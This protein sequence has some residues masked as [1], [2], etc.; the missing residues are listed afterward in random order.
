MQVLEIR[1]LEQEAGYIY[2]RR[3]YRATALLLL[4]TKNVEVPIHF[5]IE[6]N[7]AGIHTIDV[8]LEASVDYPLL[9]VVK[10]LK[11]EILNMDQ[12]G[13]LPC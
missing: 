13:L 2:Y 12:K 5:I 3:T 8:R 1:V 4:L 6:T 10:A 9:P 11:S 7:A